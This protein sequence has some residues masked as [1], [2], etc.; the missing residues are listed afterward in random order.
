MDIDQIFTWI[1]T[2]K[3]NYPGKHQEAQPRTFQAF[4]PVEPK[5][6]FHV[7]FKAIGEYIKEN[8][9]SGKSVNIRG[10]GA[11]TF[12]IESSLVQP[13]MFTTVDFRK[14]LDE[15]RSERKHNHK[16]RPCFVVDPQLKVL[17]SRYPG[18]EEISSTKSQNSIYQQGFGMI[19]CNAA[20]IAAASYL[21][22]EVVSSAIQAF[23]T[24]VIDLTRLG[25]DMNIDLG[26]CKVRISGKNLSYAYR[27]DFVGQ[28]NHTS[29]EKKIK[30]AVTPTSS[31]WKTT[32]EQKWAKSTLSSL[33]KVPN[34]AAVQTLN[35]K[36]LA[37]KIMSLDLNSTEK[38][39]TSKTKA[40][41]LPKIEGKKALERNH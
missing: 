35:E 34:V 4:K 15:Q 36:T 31:F 21:G 37:L 8:L 38:T 30:K 20:P 26:F 7:I 40:L 39:T 11:F 32:P 22:K 29:F 1:L 25:Y 2:H 19:F 14:D 13:A 5:S 17:L 9:T 27:S 24:A 18:K 41:N 6:Q 3:T 28:L 23:V 12:E 33:F 10:F 16:F